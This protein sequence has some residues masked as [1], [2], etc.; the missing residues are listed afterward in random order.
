MFV[1]LSH[2]HGGDL[3]RED[4][5][6]AWKQHAGGRAAESGRL[7][8]LPLRGL[9]HGVVRRGDERSART[10]QPRSPRG[11]DR[12][13]RTQQSLPHA[14]LPHGGVSRRGLAAAV[15]RTTG[16]GRPGWKRASGEDGV[17]GTATG[18]GTVHQQEL[19]ESGRRDPRAE[20][21]AQAHPL[22]Q[23]HAHLRAAGR[24][25]GGKQGADDR[26][27]V[28]GGQQ[29]AGV[30]AVAGVCEPREPRDAG[31]KHRKQDASHD[32]EAD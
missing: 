32:R 4:L 29:C 20:Q 22:P 8:R 5:R 15:A 1:H 27:A 10:R 25:A 7:G 23:L 19:V 9:L 11:G 14:V 12:Q 6:P 28:S 24:A 17:D 3:Q 21:Q 13:Q 16:A 30:A 2:L 26:A 31:T 18:G